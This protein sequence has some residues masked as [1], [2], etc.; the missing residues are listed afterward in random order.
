MLKNNTGKEQRESLSL[1]A[2]CLAGEEGVEPKD[3]GSGVVEKLLAEKRIVFSPD[4]RTVVMGEE[5]RRK[6]LLGDP[7]FSTE[8]TA[9][10]AKVIAQSRETGILQT[11]LGKRVGRTAPKDVYY[12]LKKLVQNGAV[13]KLKVG[14]PNTNLLVH[15]LFY[16]EACFTFQGKNSRLYLSEPEYVSRILSLLARERVEREELVE[17][18]LPALFKK[19]KTEKVL[20]SLA[21]KKVIEECVVD[22]KCWLSLRKELQTRKTPEMRNI[23]FGVLFLGEIKRAGERGITIS[24]L[25]EKLGAEKK[26]VYRF[27]NIEVKK[28]NKE[29]GYKMESEQRLQRLR[30]FWKESGR[31]GPLTKPERRYKALLGLLKKEGCVRLGIETGRLISAECREDAAHTIDKRTVYRMGKRAESEGFGRVVFS[32]ERVFFLVNTDTKE[33]GADSLEEDGWSPA[34]LGHGLV[35]RAVHR[36]LFSFPDFVTPREF[37]FTMRVGDIAS[38]FVKRKTVTEKQFSFLRRNREK[39]LVGI[40]KKDAICFLDGRVFVTVMIALRDAL[41]TLLEL[42]AVSAEDGETDLKIARV[43]AKRKTSIVLFKETL[44]EYNHPEQTESYWRDL[45]VLF[46]AFG[47]T[48]ESKAAFYH[49]E[50]G[51][52]FSEAIERNKAQADVFMRRSSRWVKRL[53]LAAHWKQKHGEG[54][55]EDGVL[56][57]ASFCVPRK[58][59]TIKRVKRTKRTE[60][61]EPKREVGLLAEVLL[62]CG[63]YAERAEEKGRH[64]TVWS[65]YKIEKYKKK[66]EVIKKASEKSLIEDTR[67]GGHQPGTFESDLELFGKYS[68]RVRELKRLLLFEQIEEEMESGV[69]EERIKNYLGKRKK[70]EEQRRYFLTTKALQWVETEEREREKDYLLNVM[71]M[72]PPW[73]FGSSLFGCTS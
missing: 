70:E 22:G 48:H 43:C 73:G 66:W 6:T 55:S 7:A 8:K 45:C 69:M 28:K 71:S 54:D 14:R 27:F 20:E 9:R 15:S 41:R 34:V 30:L 60:Q 18:R 31:T 4:R 23:P 47:N 25:S 24:E 2:L 12:F 29:V 72:P 40:S 39:T 57:E 1:A 35:C 58:N 63:E 64:K 3:L 21:E 68:D 67:P 44:F 33:E 11:E 46:K 37:L 49:G 16:D 62:A 13:V 17:R 36:H 59:K 51:R 10:M 61:K 52:V 56:K 50:K 19:E 53:F 65:K 26:S 32:E 38:C 42:G 5:E